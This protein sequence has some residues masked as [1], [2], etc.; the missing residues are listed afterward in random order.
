M[1][2]GFG[3]ERSNQGKTHPGGIYDWPLTRAA[4]VYRKGT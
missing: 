3:I 2:M 4:L 1:E